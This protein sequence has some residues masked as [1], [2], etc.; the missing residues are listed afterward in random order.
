MAKRFITV[1]VS[2]NQDKFGLELQEACETIGKGQIES[3]VVI[4]PTQYQ[5]LPK[6]LIMY[7]EVKSLKEPGGST[8][9]GKNNRPNTTSHKTIRK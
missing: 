7:S 9:K 8:G 3:T 1:D 2:P 5:P 6:L 4:P